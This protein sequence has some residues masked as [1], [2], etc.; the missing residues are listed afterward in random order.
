MIAF[1]EPLIENIIYL[2]LYAGSSVSV[3]KFSGIVMMLSQRL[4]HLN[5]I[6]LKNIPVG[7]QKKKLIFCP[8]PVIDV[9]LIQRL[10]DDLLAA[11]EKLDEIY[12][13]L[14]MGW[15]G[16]LFLHTVSDMYFVIFW[17]LTAQNYFFLINCLL[18]WLTSS[19]WQLFLINSACHSASVEVFILKLYSFISNVKIYQ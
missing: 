14:M 1:N 13:W 6:A 4:H 18:A 19:F 9:T 8:G 12:T 17:I 7:K 16:N 2:I 3:T 10:Y 15:I 5:E 11:G